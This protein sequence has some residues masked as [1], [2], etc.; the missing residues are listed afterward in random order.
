MAGPIYSRVGYLPGRRRTENEWNWAV[1][2]YQSLGET[3][4]V[5]ILNRSPHGFRKE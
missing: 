3:P 5:K 1:E 2:G 4:M